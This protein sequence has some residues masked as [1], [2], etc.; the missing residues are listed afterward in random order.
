[1][2]SERATLLALAIGC[3]IGAMPFTYLGLP[4]GTTRPTVEEYFPLL[5]KIGRKMMGFNKLLSYDGCLILVNSVLSALPT[6]Y[7]CTFKLSPA[8]IEQIDKYRKHLLW[9]KGDINR[10]G[11]C[12]VKW[13][14]AWQSKHQGGLGILDLRLQNTSLLLIFL[15][16]FYNHDNQPC[17]HLTWQCLYRTSLVPHKKKLVGSFWWKDVMSLLGEFLKIEACHVNKG[18]TTCFWAD[19]W[20]FS[21]ILHKS[22]QLHSFAKKKNISVSK[23]LA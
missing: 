18:N 11:G 22:P 14:K 15:H 2:S 20:D 9:D 21:V 13:E 6:Y 5:N 10:R 1:M 17:V 12:L 4:M 3:A 16:K 23:F 7:L 8:I 19:T